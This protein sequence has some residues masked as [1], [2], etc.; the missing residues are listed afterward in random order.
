MAARVGPGQRPGHS[1]EA[2]ARRGEA[3]W[4]TA[5]RLGGAL[6]ERDASQLPQV[7]DNELRNSVS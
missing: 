1:D 4:Q 6:G 2:D 7:R 5:I 3:Q